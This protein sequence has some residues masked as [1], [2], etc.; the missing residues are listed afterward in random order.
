MR[1]PTIPRG[2]DLWSW[3]PVVVILVFAVAGLGVSAVRVGR[4]A[5]D[6]RRERQAVAAKVRE[7][8]AEKA[9]LEAAIE[10]LGSAAAVER[11]AKEK[12]NLQKPGEEV[13]VVV[14]EGRFATGTT[15]GRKRL[16]PFGWLGELIDFFRR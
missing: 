1:L 8:E 12:F 10:A 16:A 2:K 4:R 9:R 5:W 14:P 11:L 15:A 13:V 3:P 6:I 7:L